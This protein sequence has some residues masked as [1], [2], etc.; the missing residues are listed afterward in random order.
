MGDA[1]HARRRHGELLALDLGVGDQLLEVTR[2]EFLARQDHHLRLGEQT[3]GLERG[4]RIEVELLVERRDGR[5][6][7][8]IDQERVAI[9]FGFGDLHRAHDA[10]R[11]TNILD[12]HGLV[13]P[14]AQ[15]LGENTTE[16]VASPARRIGNDQRDRLAGIGLLREGAQRREQ[17]CKSKSRNAVHCSSRSFSAGDAKLAS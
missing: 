1:A 16:K 2:R 10:A 15:S 11:P 4:Q 12:H 14:R 13:E 8:M 5:E 9:G 3:H 17:D 6:P 7:E